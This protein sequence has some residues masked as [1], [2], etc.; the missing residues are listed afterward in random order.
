M[1]RCAPFPH[2]QVSDHPHDATRWSYYRVVHANA[3]EFHLTAQDSCLPCRQLW[4]WVSFSVYTGMR[5]SR[6][7]VSGMVSEGDIFIGVQDWVPLLAHGKSLYM[8]VS[9]P[10]HG[11]S[12]LTRIFRS[13][14]NLFESAR[15]QYDTS[16]APP[17]LLQYLYKTRLSTLCHFLGHLSFL[18]LATCDCST[19]DIREYLFKMG[20]KDLW[21]VRRI[22]ILRSLQSI[23]T[24]LRYLRR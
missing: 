7:L 4:N 14:A 5:L 1:A 23:L 8:I 3:T 15:M 16:V 22:S 20:V 21:T 19:E 9:F 24:S 17:L 10:Q 13:T 2:V 6:L 11:L 12:E 18:C